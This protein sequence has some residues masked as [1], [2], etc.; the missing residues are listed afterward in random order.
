MHVLIA[1]DETLSHTDLREML[2]DEGHEVVGEARAGTEALALTHA[3]QPVPVFMD[4]G[5]PATSKRLRFSKRWRP[6]G[7]LLDSPPTRSS[8]K[9]DRRP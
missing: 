5:I 1:E 6:M 9:R 4:A 3:P 7:S 8:A 2:E